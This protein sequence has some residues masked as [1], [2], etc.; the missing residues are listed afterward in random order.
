MKKTFLKFIKFLPDLKR[1]EFFVGDFFFNSYGDNSPTRIGC[2]YSTSSLYDE[3][4]GDSFIV[5]VEIFEKLPKVEYYDEEEIDSNKFI[6]GYVP[7]FPLMNKYK[8]HNFLSIAQKNK[9][10][11]IINLS[12]KES[13][14]K[15][16]EELPSLHSFEDA[17]KDEKLKEFC[18]KFLS[19]KDET[20]ILP[21]FDFISYLPENVDGWK[22]VTFFCFYSLYKVGLENHLI[23]NIKGN[24]R[25]GRKYLNLSM[26]FIY[27]MSEGKIDISPK[28]VEESID[29][30]KLVKEKIDGI[31]NIS[32]YNESESYCLTASNNETTLEVE[33]F[34]NCMKKILLKAVGKLKSYNCIEVTMNFMNIL[35][36][37]NLPKK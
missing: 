35:K 24:Y 34:E 6:Y 15:K 37:F 33:K 16:W 29:G 32:F 14:P 36:S 8:E 13:S 26:Q 5:I 10:I 31:T 4:N 22:L 7:E 9:I 1:S 30:I 23:S 18:K 11:T 20:E 21:I 17:K 12:A 28:G 19:T 2:K 25:K 27:K 3:K